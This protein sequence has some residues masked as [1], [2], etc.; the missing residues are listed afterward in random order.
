MK[1][2]SGNS[3][4]KMRWAGDGPMI[5]NIS[6]Y[7]TH[8]V[9]GFHHMFTRGWNNTNLPKCPTIFEIPNDGNSPVILSNTKSNIQLSKFFRAVETGHTECCNYTHLSLLETNVAP[10]NLQLFQMNTASQLRW[11]VPSLPVSFHFPP[12]CKFF[13][14]KTNKQTLPAN[15]Q[16]VKEACSTMY[17]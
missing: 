12:K 10:G 17:L 1:C 8:W 5:G 7:Q 13:H 9:C 11:V 3:S 6:F 2:L 16:L 14:L 4:L 15:L